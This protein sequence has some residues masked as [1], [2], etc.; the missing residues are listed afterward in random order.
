[1][2]HSPDGAIVPDKEKFRYVLFLGSVQYICYILIYNSNTISVQIM[3]KRL[4]QYGIV[5]NVGH[6]ER[7]T[8]P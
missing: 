2:Y 8:L 3:Q 7:N 4:L 5:T 1:M 6:T